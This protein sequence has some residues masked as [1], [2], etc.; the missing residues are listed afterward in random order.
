MSQPCSRIYIK[1]RTRFGIWKVFYNQ[2]IL[3]EDILL[4]PCSLV[5]KTYGIYNITHSVSRLLISIEGF[6]NLFLLS[7]D[8]HTTPQHANKMVQ[9]HSLFSCFRYKYV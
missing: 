2:D 6:H 5:R 7:V 1:D 3:S 4:L 8:R 9:T